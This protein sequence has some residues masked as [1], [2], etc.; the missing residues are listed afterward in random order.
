MSNTEYW[1]EALEY[2]IEDLQGDFSALHNNID[3]ISKS[4]AKSCEMYYE[5]ASYTYPSS[6]ENENNEIERLKKEIEVLKNHECNFRTVSTSFNRDDGTI[7]TTG[8]CTICER[9]TTT[10]SYK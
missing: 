2:A 7:S 1:S 4:L 6:H 9:V 8:R 3:E 5:V 10:Y